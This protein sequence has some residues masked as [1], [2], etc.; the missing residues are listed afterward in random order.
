MHLTQLLCV[1]DQYNY[2]QRAWIQKH[3]NFK[4]ILIYKYK[5]FPCEPI[6]SFIQQK[7]AGLTFLKTLKV[8]HYPLPLSNEF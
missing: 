2:F 4:N 8:Y 1:F 7:S 6:E 5:Q 3:Y